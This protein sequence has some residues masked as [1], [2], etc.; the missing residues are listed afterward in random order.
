MK[1]FKRKTKREKIC[2]II[3]QMEYQEQVGCVEWLVET[4]LKS[5]HLKYRAGMKPQSITEGVLESRTACLIVFEQG[6]PTCES[7]GLKTDQ[8]NLYD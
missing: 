1:L 3:K 8:I 2:E 4:V 5:K 6:S 7:M